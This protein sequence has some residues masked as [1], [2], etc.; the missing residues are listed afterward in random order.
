MIK[1][2][3]PRGYDGDNKIPSYASKVKHYAL[4][5]EVTGGYVITLAKLT[6]G[7]SVSAGNQLTHASF[8]SF[9][10]HG[11]RKAAVRTRVSG[12]NRE[13]VAVQNAMIGAGIEFAPVTPCTSED[14]LNALGDWFRGHNSEIE[15]CS[16]VS[17]R[18]H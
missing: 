10:D 8:E 3:T 9:D 13:F 16:V 7:E 4:Q 12:Y 11:R 6:V 2:F 1:S 14:M 17:Q 15:K 18:C 5:A